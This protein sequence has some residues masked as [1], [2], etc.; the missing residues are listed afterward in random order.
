MSWTEPSEKTTHSPTAHAPTPGRSRPRVKEEKTRQLL[1]VPEGA[2]DA[3]LAFYRQRDEQD[4]LLHASGARKV[5]GTVYALGLQRLEQG[6]DVFE[7]YKV[8][9]AAGVELP[10]QAL[11]ILESLPA[12]CRVICRIDGDGNVWTASHRDKTK[13]TR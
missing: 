9:G 10:P 8:L 13:I 11:A 1:P 7:S 2:R 6:E 4:E 12:D 5:R 3:L